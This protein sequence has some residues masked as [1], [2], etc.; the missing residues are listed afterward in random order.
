M[1]GAHDI[2]IERYLPATIMSRQWKEIFSFQP[3]SDRNTIRL[4]MANR[5]ESPFWP[6]EYKNYA[7]INTDHNDYEYMTY[8]E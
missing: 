5:K 3:I 6:D 4:N 2:R 1:I 7:M 8:L